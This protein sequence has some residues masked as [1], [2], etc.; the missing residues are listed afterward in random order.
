MP[1]RT[2][3]SGHRPKSSKRRNRA[4]KGHIVAS[5]TPEDVAKNPRSYTGQYLKT[6]LKNAQANNQ[7]RSQAKKLKAAESSKQGPHCGQ[8]HAGRRGEKSALLYRP[9]SQDSVEKCPGEQPGQVTGQKAQSG[10]IEQARATLWPA[11][12]R[13]TWRKIRAPIPANISR[14]C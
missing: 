3:R 6:L 14:L 8:R 11:A 12:R 1:R 7:V 10:G 4:S 5:G 13:K 9:I 2:T